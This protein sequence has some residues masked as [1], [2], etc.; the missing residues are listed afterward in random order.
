MYLG[1][2]EFWRDEMRPLVVLTHNF[3]EFHFFSQM[4]YRLHHAHQSFFFDTTLACQ[5]WSGKKICSLFLIKKSIDN[6]QN[7]FQGRN[8]QLSMESSNQAARKSL[9]QPRSSETRFPE[10]FLPNLCLWV[11]SNSNGYSLDCKTG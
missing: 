10:Y 8:F 11:A 3:L 7:R 1:R 2:F 4:G 5:Q 6:H 9:W